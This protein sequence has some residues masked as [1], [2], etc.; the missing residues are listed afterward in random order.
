MLPQK[1]TNSN[2]CSAALVVYLLL[3]SASYYLHSPST[4]SGARYRRSTCSNHM[5]TL[6]LAAVAC[7][8]MGWISAQRSVLTLEACIIA[9]GGHSEHLLWH[10]LPEITVATHHNQFFSEPPMTTHNWLSPEPSTFERTQL[11]QVI[12]FIMWWWC[13]VRYKNTQLGQFSFLK[14]MAISTSIY[15]HYRN[16]R[17]TCTVKQI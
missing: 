15:R 14:Q 7:C 17:P 6:R 11:S 9:E 4:A 3:F 12:G 1:K 13:V 16:Y 2:C 5:D 10:C 8:D